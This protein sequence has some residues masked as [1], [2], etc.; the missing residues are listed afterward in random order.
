VSGKASGCVYGAA[1]ITPQ[2]KQQFKFK[3]HARRNTQAI[4]AVRGF[5]GHSLYKG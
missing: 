3:P 5:A 2:V 1:E 4:L